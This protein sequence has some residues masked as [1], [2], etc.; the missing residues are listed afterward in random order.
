ML[1][2]K[3]CVIYTFHKYNENVKYFAK[4]CYQN[5][6]ILWIFVQNVNNIKEICDQSLIPDFAKFYSRENVGYDFGGWSYG[7]SKIDKNNYD[8]FMF[9]N[10]SA[11]GPLTC[12][13]EWLDIYT[14]KLNNFTV[15]V[16]ST[17]NKHGCGSENPYTDTHVQS[18]AFCLNKTGIEIICKTKI[19]TLENLYSDKVKIVKNKEIKMSRDILNA[20]YNICELQSVSKDID[21]R[22]LN[23]EKINSIN[24]DLL[25]NEHFEKKSI[26]ADEILFVKTTR[27]IDKKFYEN[28]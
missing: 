28:F 27:D 2:N 5:D 21:F 16:G 15:I 24:C 17:I 6:N 22:E 4:K 18:Y 14:S 10:S 8:Y 23:D 26:S 25:F 20:G 11:R 19:M 13:K 3:T 9:V 1:Q 7:L 12:Q